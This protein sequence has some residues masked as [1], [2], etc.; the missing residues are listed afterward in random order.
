MKID[1]LSCAQEELAEAV[2]YYNEQC[3]GLGYEF[4]AGVKAA[5]SRIA[6]FP[7]A[8]PAYSARAK[9]CIVN[10][11]PYGIL[12]QIRKDCLLVL[13]IMHLKREPK[14]WQDRLE[15]ASGEQGNAADNASR[16]P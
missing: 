8:W 16:G 5:L 10:R 3:P 4:A 7:D 1:I 2:E 13:A 15:N 6:A 12:Y 14:R 9:R 11:F